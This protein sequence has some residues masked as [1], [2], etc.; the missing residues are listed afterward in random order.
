MTLLSL[1]MD[2]MSKLYPR[3]KLVLPV[4]LMAIAF[5]INTLFPALWMFMGIHLL[6]ISARIPRTKFQ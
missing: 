1:S 5:K 3:V 2:F 4:A 6:L